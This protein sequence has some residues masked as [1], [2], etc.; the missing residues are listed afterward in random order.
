MAFFV[1]MPSAGL[2][3]QSSFAMQDSQAVL[4]IVIDDFGEDR[5]GVAE[6]LDIPVPLTIAVLPGMEYSQE[7]A[8]NA[9]LKGHEVILHLPME[10]QSAMPASYY[11]PV[12]IKNSFSCQ[13]AKET[14]LSAYASIP[15]AVGVNIHM[16]TGVSQNK[17]LLS[18]IMEEAKKQD[19][20]FLDSK[21]TM[22]TKCALSA[23]ETG[24][25]FYERDFFLEPPGT[26]SYATAEREL[27]KSA[28]HAKT[29]GSAVAIGHIGPV[30][31][32]ETARA[33]AQNLE[34]IE[35]MGVKIVPLSQLPPISP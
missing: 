22:G 15:H 17:E 35:A 33:I 4:A 32:A 21:T 28:E 14:F 7:D 19:A 18:A 23:K 34:K 25:T 1:T 16:G 20:Y 26:P 12:L 3:K 31:R 27:L 30:G 9:H 29:H 24:V 2:K 8:N 5:T 6:M 11:G 13:E 10:N